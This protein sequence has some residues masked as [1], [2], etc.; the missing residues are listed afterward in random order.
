[1][2]PHTFPESTCKQCAWIK[3]QQE[4]RDEHKRRD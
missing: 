2:K 4:R 3:E 1:M